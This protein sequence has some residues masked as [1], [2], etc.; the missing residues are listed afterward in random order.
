DTECACENG[1]GLER[2]P[3][4]LQPGGFPQETLEGIGI[5]APFAGLNAQ[6]DL[7]RKMVKIT[8]GRLLV[9]F[10]NKQTAQHIEVLR[11]G[12]HTH[13]VILDNPT[14]TLAIAGARRKDASEPCRCCIP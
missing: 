5:L 7:A 13:Y 11:I 8:G 4:P 6:D 3:E 1:L 9:T 10:E 2:G 14:S 12:I